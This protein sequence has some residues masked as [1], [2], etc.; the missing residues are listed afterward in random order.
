M[1]EASS[2][3]NYSL[4]GGLL[5]EQI[6]KILPLISYLSY[7]SDSLIMQEGQRN[8]SIYF[9]LQGKVEVSKAGHHIVD[10]PEG[11]AFGE[12]EL[13][14]VMPSAATIRALE[15]V[16]LAVIS[17]TSLHKIYCLDLC[18]FSIMIMNLARDLSRRLRHMDDV[19]SHDCDDN[20]GSIAD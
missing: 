4:F 9:I 10:L 18:V 13:L 16:R 12:M 8:D 1:I 15:P 19:V 20:I 17:N 14:D 6:E 11:Q 5:T 2:L 3:Q 7:D